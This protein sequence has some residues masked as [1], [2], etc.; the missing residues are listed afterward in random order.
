M[1][2]FGEDAMGG[3]AG[4]REQGWEKGRREYQDHQLLAMGWKGQPL[5]FALMQNTALANTIEMI[6]AHCRTHAFPH[7]LADASA[8]A[9][10]YVEQ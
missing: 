8:V 6:S 10:E 3:H 5:A 2:G 9:W 4:E 7:S 1:G